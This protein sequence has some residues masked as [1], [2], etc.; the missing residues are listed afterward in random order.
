[1]PKTPPKRQKKHTRRQGCCR[2]ERCR[3]GPNI[4]RQ[5]HGY[6]FPLTLPSAFILDPLAFGLPRSEAS[7]L[8]SR[9]C[10]TAA[11]ETQ[12]GNITHTF[13]PRIPLIPSRSVPLHH[14]HPVNPVN[15]VKKLPQRQR[16]CVSQ[17][18]V[19]R[20]ALPWAVMRNKIA[21]SRCPST[22]T[23]ENSP[24]R[25]LPERM[26]AGPQTTRPLVLM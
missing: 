25:L 14:P 6:R 20:H 8:Y 11:L 1:M 9:T 22:G 3:R 16:R 18:R 4:G 19:A 12:L 7:P 5:R 24:Y 26:P 2:L 10:G 21:P 23:V 13:A 17:P 15:P